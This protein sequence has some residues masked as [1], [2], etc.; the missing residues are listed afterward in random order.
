MVLMI[1]QERIRQERINRGWSQSNIA[2]L[3]GIS[4]GMLQKIETNQRKPSFE[5]LVKLEDLFCMDY[6]DLFGLPQ[7]QLRQPERK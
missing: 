3:I 7:R 1:R 6:R 4:Q 2:N 5:V